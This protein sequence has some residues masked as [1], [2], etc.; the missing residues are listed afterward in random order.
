MNIKKVSTLFCLVMVILSMVN[1]TALAAE[2]KE[3]VIDLGDGFYVAETI[4]YSPMTRSRDTVSGMTTDDLYYGSTWIGTATLYASFD[5]SGSSARATESNMEGTGR[6]GGTYSN[7]T[8]SCSGNTAY[9][10]AY[11]NYNGIQ[12]TLRLSLSCT[13]DGTLY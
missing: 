6:N 2:P 12:K 11:F 7:G 5:I 4:M 9:G 8:T 3:N 10:T 1:T 13:A